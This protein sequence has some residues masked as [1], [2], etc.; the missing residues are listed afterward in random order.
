MRKRLD[1]AIGAPHP[2]GESAVD[3]GGFTVLEALLALGLVGIIFVGI[4]GAL[5]TSSKATLID[6]EQTTADNLAESQLEHLRNQAYDSSSS[7][8]QYS[9]ISGVPAGYS[10]SLAVTRLD[11]E[12]DGAGDDDGLQ[13]VV[14][15]V[16]HRSRTV[17]TLEAYKVR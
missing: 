2:R 9:L 11:P 3:Q 13:K 5:G 4:L 17:A 16:Q 7:P 6:D 15:T 8:P 12:G 1:P 14:V 10:I